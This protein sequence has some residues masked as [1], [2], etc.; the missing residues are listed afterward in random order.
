[1]GG[2]VM[3][4]SHHGF[5]INSSTGLLQFD[6]E[7]DDPPEWSPQITPFSSSLDLPEANTY[8]EP[9][10]FY[11]DRPHTPQVIRVDLSQKNHYDYWA[12]PNLMKKPS[13]FPPTLRNIKDWIFWRRVYGRH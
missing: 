12:I 9:P 3:R 7:V 2:S 8:L 13:L 1:M 5:G 10:R 6:E 11:H 4:L